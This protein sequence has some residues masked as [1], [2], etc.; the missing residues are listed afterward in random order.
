MYQD[1]APH[2]LHNEYKNTQPNENS[3]VICYSAGN[4]AINKDG[5]LPTASQIRG[6][7]YFLFCID[8]VE[9]FGCISP[10]VAPQD[11]EYIGMRKAMSISD[12]VLRYALM[13]GAHILRWYDEYRVCPVC[14]NKLTHKEN[15]RALCCAHCGKTIYPTISPAVI[16]GIISG[17]KILFTKYAVGEYSHFALVAGFNEVGETIEQT[18]HREVMEEVGLKVKNLRYYKSQPWALSSSLL[19]GFYC[20][21]DGDD[22]VTLDKNELSVAQWVNIDDIPDIV[23]AING[24]LTQEMMINAK[25]YI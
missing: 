25:N 17:R 23:G 3:P 2:I 19:F 7:F 6:K 13:C 21:V 18:V 24:S 16:V 20:Y 10:D 12:V 1:I 8:D 14:G 15:E 11:I 4:I 9:Y 22:T 5:T